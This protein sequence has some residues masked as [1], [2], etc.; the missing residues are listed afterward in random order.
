VHIAPNYF[1]GVRRV[2]P[3]DPAA[4]FAFFETFNQPAAVRG[5][6]GDLD[7]SRWAVGRLQPSNIGQPTVPN[8][9]RLA[10]MPSGDEYPPDDMQVDGGRLLMGSVVQNY[11]YAGLMIRQPFAF[12]GR[13]GTIEVYVDAVVESSLASYIQIAITA[14]PVPCPTYLIAENDETGA[15]PRHALILP[16]RSNQGLGTTRAQIAEASVYDTYARTALSPSTLLTGTNC[17]AVSEGNLNRVQI[18]V[19]QSNVAVWMSDAFNGSTYPNFRKIYEA[20]IDLPF[21]VGYVHLAARNHASVKYHFETTWVYRW[22][23]IT[24]DGP[25]LATARAYEIPDGTATAAIPGDPDA[26]PPEGELT[27]M[28]LGYNVPDAGVGPLTFTGSVNLSGAVSAQ[29]TLNMFMQTLGNTATTSWG[30]L[31]RFNSGSWRTRTLTADEVTA[32]NTLGSG[33]LIGLLADVNLGDLQ[34]G[35]NTIEF[36][37]VDVPLGYPPMVANIDLLVHAS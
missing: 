31:Y 30:L 12:T 20:A 15:I 32:A 10:S 23:T 36:D 14:D 17:P 29:L 34:S 6:G 27:V 28:A 13:T 35:V 5:R 37:T 21:E 11:G 19:S 24:F 18:I 7:S 33:G 9:V 3:P 2:N 16:F 4:G 1:Q 22:D 25:V 8:W 26:D